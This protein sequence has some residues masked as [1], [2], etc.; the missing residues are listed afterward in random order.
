MLLPPVLPVM[1]VL[2]V[3]PVPPVSPVCCLCDAI[4]GVCGAAG[5]WLTGSMVLGR[6][7]PVSPVSAAH[8]QAGG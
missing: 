7:E 2:P 1:P 8:G 3:L 5:S 4:A 6:C